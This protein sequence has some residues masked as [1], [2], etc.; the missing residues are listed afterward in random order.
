MKKEEAKAKMLKVITEKGK[1]SPEE[2]NKLTKIAFIQIYG[3]AKELEADGQIILEQIDDLKTYSLAEAE[4]KKEKKSAKEKDESGEKEPTISEDL[5]LE[6]PKEEK[7]VK[8]GG[9]DMTKYK[10]NGNEYNKGRL[11]HA[12][13][14]AYA[15]EKKPTL[16]QALVLFPN[17]LVRP[18]GLIAEIG[19]ARKM[20]KQHQ[21]FF[22]KPE[23]EIK[24]KDSVVA[25]SNQMTPDRI[26]AIL[27]IARK[28]LGYKIK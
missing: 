19:E 8:T 23:E 6:E 7:V 17:E 3:I 15:K 21:R 26:G 27:N 12:I 1:I 16:K 5:N 9:R 11:A 18:Y 24:L 14:S 4:P 13:I 22:I 20:S 10:F 2:I 28:E 25:C